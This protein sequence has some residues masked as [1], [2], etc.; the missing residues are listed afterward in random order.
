[1]QRVWPETYQSMT[2]RMH[3]GMGLSCLSLPEERGLAAERGWLNSLSV[4]PGSHQLQIS[5]G[6]M[7]LNINSDV[8]HEQ[9]L[10]SGVFSF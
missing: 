6:E 4:G 10:D 8:V 2:H 5:S 3:Q 9:L 7:T 1:M